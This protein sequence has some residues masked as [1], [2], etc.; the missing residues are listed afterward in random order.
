MLSAQELDAQL[1]PGDVLV[2]VRSTH[3]GH[4]CIIASVGTLIELR[5][6]YYRIVP[7]M[8]ATVIGAL[9]MASLQR[10]GL[11]SHR[12]IVMLQLDCGVIVIDVAEYILDC[13]RHVSMCRS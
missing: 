2:C 7:G 6:D 4:A 9:G 1:R 3:I 11:R 8:L 13:W 12:S 5:W 10:L